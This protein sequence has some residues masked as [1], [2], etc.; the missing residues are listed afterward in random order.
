MLFA[1]VV[2]HVGENVPAPLI[3][4]VDVLCDRRLPLLVH[5]E[6]LGEHVVGLESIQVDVKDVLAFVWVEADDFVLDKGDLVQPLRNEVS[7]RV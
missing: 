4:P 2:I 5:I 7:G 6:D 3:D 1:E